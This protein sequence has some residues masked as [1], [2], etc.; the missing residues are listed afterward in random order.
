MGGLSSETRCVFAGGYYPYINV[1]QYITTDTTGNSTDFG[2]L[3]VARTLTAGAANGTRG[4]FGGGFSTTYDTVIDYI[5]I[6]NTGNA[7]D[8]GDLS[9]GRS[10]AGGCSGT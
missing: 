5:T 9:Q 1:M 2:D 3:T 8:F 7:S 4:V 10:G 6:A